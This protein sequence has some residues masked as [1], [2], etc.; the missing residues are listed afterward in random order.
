MITDD[1]VSVAL[2]TRRNKDTAPTRPLPTRA[3]G[4]PPR[5][6]DRPPCRQR[7]FA[8][9]AKRRAAQPP[10][11]GRHR[12]PGAGGRH[13]VLGARHR[14]NRG[15]GRRGLLQHLDDRL[16]GDPGRPL[17][18]RAGHRLRL[19]AYRQCRHQRRKTSRPDHAGGAR[20]DPARRHHRA[21]NFRA[22]R[23]S[24]MPGWFRTI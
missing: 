7:P 22:T 11:A 16:S 17:L 12:R 8:W 4:P 14:R 20:P 24:R 10:A 21:V 15:F 13:G 23:R 18:C 19:P 5:R 2:S 3:P 6:K 9:P 1:S